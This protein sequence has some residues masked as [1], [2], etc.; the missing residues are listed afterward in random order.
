MGFRPGWPG[1][2][3]YP[4]QPMVSQMRAVLDAYAAAGGRYREQV[5]PDSGHAPHIEYPAEFQAL[6]LEHLSDE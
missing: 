2:D 5:I 4:P 6:L 3:V 1:A